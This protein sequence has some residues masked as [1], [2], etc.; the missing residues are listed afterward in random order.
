MISL[1]F[2]SYFGIILWDE[3]PTAQECFKEQEY[4]EVKFR[5]LNEER[6]FFPECLELGKT[7][8]EFMESYGTTPVS[9]SG[10]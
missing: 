6:Q 2:F 9:N 5:H 10:D 7:T 8:K 3:Y 1:Y 4:F